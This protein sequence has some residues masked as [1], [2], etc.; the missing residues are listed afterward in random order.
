M[1]LIEVQVDRLVG[2]THHFGGL[3]VGNIASAEH[4]GQVSDPAAAALQGLDKM[5]WVAGL[6][7]PQVIL[8]PQPRPDML[9]LHQLGFRGGLADVLH[10]ASRQSPQILSAAMSCSAMWTANAATVCP[11]VDSQD[12]TLWI[13]IA[14]LQG[15]LHRAIE[16]NQT[17]ADLQRVFADVAQ[18]QPPLPGGS[19]M[20][21][22]GA[23][24]HMRLGT[25]ENQGGIHLFVYGDGVPR[26]SQY[27]P[28]QSEAASRAIAR[29]M[30]L[31]PSRVFFL[32]QHARAIDA[33]AFHNDV[34]AASHHGL[35]LHHELAFQETSQWSVIEQ[36]YRAVCGNT[37]TRIEVTSDELS[38]EDAVRTYLFNSQIVSSR[39]HA[40]PILICPSQVQSH[41]GAHRLVQRWL[42]S[43][44]F[45]AVRF[46]DLTLSMAGGGG[47]ACLRL[48]V[49]LPEDQLDRVPQ[50]WLWNE[51]LDRALRESIHRHYPT[52][53]TAEELAD[54]SFVQ[55]AEI[56]REQLQQEWNQAGERC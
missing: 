20:R 21:D 50:I 40:A 2:P 13:A 24:N 34:V 51:S 32:K 42:Q 8:P 41:A 54:P 49:P 35:L 14:N 28:R 7:V 29:T 6:G 36:R 3:G 47:P 16:A 31:D 37:L 45:S 9:F 48:R 27:W 12:G 1:R 11:A 55:S 43:N 18:L 52:R 39:E 19:A 38:I 10:Q 23:A 46:V 5:R 53:V 22:E 15:S 17:A 33:G 56:A 44:L 25:A 26:P 4:A 30:S